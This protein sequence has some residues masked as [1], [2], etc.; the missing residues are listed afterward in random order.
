M[1]VSNMKT[2]PYAD[3]KISFYNTDTTTKSMLP[4]QMELSFLIL[5]TG[6]K[7]LM[8]DLT[9]DDSSKD[10]AKEKGK[11]PVDRKKKDKPLKAY[12]RKNKTKTEKLPE[13][14]DFKVEPIIEI[15]S[16][17]RSTKRANNEKAHTRKE[18]SEIK[19]CMD[20][21]EKASERKTRVKSEGKA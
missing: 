3:K 8:Q 10:N 18:S 7:A 16:S 15:G 5:T 21:K 1:Q 19:E 2:I 11:E 9:M 14:S 12:S 13:D 6:V 17:S 4:N 20:D